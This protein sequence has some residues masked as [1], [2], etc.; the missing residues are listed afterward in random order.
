M[1]KVNIAGDTYKKVL[2]AKDSR[3][4]ATERQILSAFYNTNGLTID[5]LVGITGFDPTTIKHTL[6][7]LKEKGLVR[8]TEKWSPMKEVA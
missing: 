5:D 4:T 3:L 7:S 2:P 8:K 1:E 6:N